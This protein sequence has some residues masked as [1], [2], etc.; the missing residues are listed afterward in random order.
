[1]LGPLLA[2]IQAR[3]PPDSDE[4]SAA[5]VVVLVVIVGVFVIDVLL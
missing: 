1:M 4:P 3:I 2:P 5:I